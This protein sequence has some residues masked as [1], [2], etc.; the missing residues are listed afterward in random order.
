VT[1]HI[2]VEDAW[3]EDHGSLFENLSFGCPATRLLPIYTSSLGQR[4]ASLE[5]ASPPAVL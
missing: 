3:A 1:A 2:G 4:E 5:V